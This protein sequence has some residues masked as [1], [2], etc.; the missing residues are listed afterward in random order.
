MHNKVT[1]KP[2]SNQVLVNG[3]NRQ[4]QDL[5]GGDYQIDLTFSDPA[6]HQAQATLWYLTG[7]RENFK[8]EQSDRAP[9]DGRY[10][11]ELRN[12][13]DWV[14][15]NLLA[16]DIHSPENMPANLSV[17]ATLCKRPSAGDNALT[18]HAQ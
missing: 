7:R 18:A 9:T 16:L 5:R 6:V 12:D 14:D 4:L 11:F 10:V 17:E 3:E 13:A 15:L 1:L 8:I 2:G